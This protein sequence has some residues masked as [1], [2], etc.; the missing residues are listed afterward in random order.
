MRRK[1]LLRLVIATKQY[2]QSQN[3]MLYEVQTSKQKKRESC[4]KF[5]KIVNTLIYKLEIGGNSK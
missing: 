2:T 5:E 4:Y 1:I 3:M